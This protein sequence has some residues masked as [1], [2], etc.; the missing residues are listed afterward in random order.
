MSRK[1]SRTVAGAAVLAVLGTTGYMAS[2]YAGGESGSG[3]DSPGTTADVPEKIDSRVLKESDE[4]IR[5]ELKD[6]SRVFL[7]YEAKKG[8]I[9]RHRT[10][11]GDWSAPKL[12]YATKT[13]SCQGIDARAHGRTVT[14]TADWASYCSD[15]EPPNES[16]A[17]VGT[18]DLTEWDTDLTEGMDGW[19]P[20]KI[21]NGGDEAR[22][23]EK[24]W[25]G[26]TTLTW[27]K[28]AGFG[29]PS[30]VYKPI[31]KRFV[32]SWRAEDGSQQV[33]FTQTAPQ[34][35]PSLTIETLKGE[36]C[37]GTGAVTEKSADSVEIRGF[38]VT[39]GKETTNCPPELFEHFFE[40]ENVD[41][42]MNLK[43]LGDKP[44]IVL[45]YQRVESTR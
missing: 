19:P 16:L 17:A 10:E 37:V 2:A 44:K 9:E 24:R 41:G 22:F 29:E 5:I 7:K 21:Y 23:V 6:K 45:T 40:V 36:R 11:K 3:A 43:E 12:I 13:D 1:L 35:R 27:K 30:N 39:E 14:V 34:K 25:D 18:G 31:P 38:E 33:T 32:G 42:P 15:G 20:A 28:G 4:H 8:L 26:T